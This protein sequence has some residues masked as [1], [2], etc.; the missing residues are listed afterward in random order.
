MVPAICEN[1]SLAVRAMT[2][3][4]VEGGGMKR[5]FAAAEEQ[6]I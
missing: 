4:T 3:G 6:R 1:C 5:V 2:I